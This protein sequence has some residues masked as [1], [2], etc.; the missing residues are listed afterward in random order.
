MKTGA[1]MRPMRS[2]VVGATYAVSSPPS[3][4]SAA[5]GGASLVDGTAGAAVAQ[6]PGG[7]A[8]HKPCSSKQASARRTRDVSARGLCRTMILVCSKESRAETKRAVQTDRPFPD[9]DNSKARSELDANTTI[10]AL[11]DGVVGARVRL[12]T[13]DVK[14]Q[15]A[16]Q[17]RRFLVEQ[18]RRTDVELHLVSR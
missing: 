15:S 7:A 5:T 2:R 3:S 6:N 9:R 10:E 14:R 11:S 1:M 8:T 13:R 17:R 16:D 12:G 4:S 18:V